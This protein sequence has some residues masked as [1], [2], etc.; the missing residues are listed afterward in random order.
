MDGVTEGPE[1]SARAAY[2]L[3]LMAVTMPF[4]YKLLEQLE[5]AVNSNQL[6]R[7]P[8]LGRGSESLHRTLRPEG[9]HLVLVVPEPGGPASSPNLGFLA[10]LSFLSTSL[11]Q[12]L[13][14]SPL[15]PHSMENS[16]PTSFSALKVVIEVLSHFP[17]AACSPSSLTGHLRFRVSMKTHYLPAWFRWLSFF[18]EAGGISMMNILKRKKK[19]ER[20]HSWFVV[21]LVSY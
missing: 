19:K 5:N 3:I 8:S 18:L 6:E 15:W 2:S 14:L 10:S 1:L 7:R 12:L 13:S 16:W 11:A 17:S 4:V 21:R 9:P 20:K